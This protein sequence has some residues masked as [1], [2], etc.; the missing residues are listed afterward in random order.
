MVDIYESRPDNCNFWV[1]PSDFTKIE[2]VYGQSKLP[3]DI[4]DLTIDNSISQY[5]KEYGDTMSEPLK[6]SLIDFN[7]LIKLDYINKTL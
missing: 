2:C 7:R 5:L 6:E 4:D 1:V 3:I